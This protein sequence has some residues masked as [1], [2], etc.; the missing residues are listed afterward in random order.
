MQIVRC[1]LVIWSLII[2]K[3][4]L[5]TYI[6][7]KHFYIE[8]KTWFHWDEASRCQKLLQKVVSRS[9]GLFLFWKEEETLMRWKT[10]LHIEFFSNR[11]FILRFFLWMLIALYFNFE[12]LK[13]KCHTQHG[14]KRI[15]FRSFCPFSFSFCNIFLSLSFTL[16][17]SFFYL[18]IKK[19]HILKFEQ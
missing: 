19:E 17:H 3:F 15:S 8:L 2:C 6:K 9:K 18:L 13:W 10:K 4:T 12:K 5:I 16:S 7:L 14:N 1:F 11:N